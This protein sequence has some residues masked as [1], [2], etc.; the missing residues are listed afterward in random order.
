MSREI[1]RVALDFAWPLNEVWEGFLS[2]DKF[3]E[4][5]CPADCAGGWSAPAQAL[6]D[7][8][9]G[10]APFDPVST[11][12][13]P[14]TADTPA[15]RAFA[16]RN[17][18]NAPE[19]Y[20]TSEFAILGEAQRLADLWNQQWSKH[21]AQEDVDALVAGERLWE[22]TRVPHTEQHREDVAKKQAEGG[23]SWLPYDNGYRP[24]AA[25]V[26]EWSL[27]GFGH[28][29]S[30]QWI[31]VK[32]RCEKAGVSDTC[33]TCGGNGSLERYPGQR[34][35]ADNW[36]PTE[37]PEG[38]GWQVWE[39]VSEGSPISPVFAERE[40]LIEWLMSPAYTWGASRP[41]SREQAEAFV[42]EGSSIGSF[43][44]IGNRLIGGD[45]AVHELDK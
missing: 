24:T 11:G 23:N 31:V 3:N 17:V 4:D 21:L 27:H 8:W 6:R 42:D 26:N 1:K 7:Q 34:E 38:E 15:V 32:A 29:S 43:V 44:V 18:Q 9:Y 35:E 14:L 10:Y 37:P 33:A 2:P 13:T 28:D 39:T 5:P 36:E 19:F 22:F 30:N 12:S 40:Q 45:A 16:E 20:G 41:L 25:E